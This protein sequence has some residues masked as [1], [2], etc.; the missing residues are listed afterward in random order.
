MKS[1]RNNFSLMILIFIFSGKDPL[2]LHLLNQELNQNLFLGA[3]QS[4]FNIQTT[5]LYLNQSIP[6]IKGA[7]VY[8]RFCLLRNKS[9][10]GGIFCMMFFF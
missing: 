2:L 3:Q 6:G 1:L 8:F 5:T 10:E 9:F 4:E 7:F